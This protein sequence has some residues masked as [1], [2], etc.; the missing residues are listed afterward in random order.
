MASGPL[1]VRTHPI[2]LDLPDLATRNE[3]H[4]VQHTRQTLLRQP[5]LA[6]GAAT[7]KLDQLVIR[8]DWHSRT[9]GS[10]GAA[11][12]RLRLRLALPRAAVVPNR[13]GGLRPAWAKIAWSAH[14]RLLP[15]ALAQIVW[16]R[17]AHVSFR[18][19][20]SERSWVG[21]FRL[22]PRPHCRARSRCIQR[23]PPLYTRNQTLLS[24]SWRLLAAH[25][26]ASPEAGRELRKHASCKRPRR[27]VPRT[28]PEKHFPLCISN[29]PSAMFGESHSRAWEWQCGGCGK[30]R[31]Q[32]AGSTQ[33]RAGRARCV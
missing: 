24:G 6:E 16:I 22:Y 7:D 20:T 2:E 30:P 15:L 11:Y 26:V 21:S 12:A 28:A 33:R 13:L 4:R 29:T 19:V 17:M 8:D 5:N 25:N 10:P 1:L 18:I 32:A 23:A 27:G 3:L 14:R 31:G 9:P